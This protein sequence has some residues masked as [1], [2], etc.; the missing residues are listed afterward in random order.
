[1]TGGAAA[2]SFTAML[3]VKGGVEV[4]LCKPAR[5]QQENN[6]RRMQAGEGVGEHA[7][8]GANSRAKGT[9]L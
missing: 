8:W 4:A 7:H 9:Q 3:A 2:E 1:M 5:F 6:Q